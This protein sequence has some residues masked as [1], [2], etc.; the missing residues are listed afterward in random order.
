MY[1]MAITISTKSQS[2]PETIW[3]KAN[4]MMAMDTADTMVPT[5]ENARIAPYEE[6]TR[7]GLLSAIIINNQALSDV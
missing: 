5:N 2:T 4:A 7:R 3:A 6:K 1:L